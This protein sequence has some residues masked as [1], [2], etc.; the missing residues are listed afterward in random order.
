MRIAGNQQFALYDYFEVTKPRETSLLVLIGACTA[1]ISSE[2]D[3]QAGI[4]FLIITTLLFG[5]AGC[6][7][8]TNYLDRE[9]DVKTC[10][11]Q[12]RALGCRTV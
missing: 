5:C 3:I 7:A 9:I 10:R 12:K 11:T 2:G 8:L 6:N 4:F 1:I